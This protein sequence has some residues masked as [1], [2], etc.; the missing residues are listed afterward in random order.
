MKSGLMAIVGKN[1][2]SIKGLEDLKGKTIAVQI[3]TIGADEAHKIEGATVKTFDSSDLACLE[4]KMVV[5][6]R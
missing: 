5:Q 2:D 1:N 3:G 6:M 4:L